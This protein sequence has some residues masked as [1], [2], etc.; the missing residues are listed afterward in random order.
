MPPDDPGGLPEDEYLGLISYVLEANGYPAGTSALQI[1]DLESIQI[2]GKEGLSEARNF[3]LV[4]VVGC[5][6]P[7]PDESW[8]LTRTSDPVLTGDRPST[9]AELS[10]ADAQPLGENTF[11]LV[12]VSP[13]APESYRGHRVEAKGLV[14]RAPNKDRINV[15]SL[16]ALGS[17]C[18]N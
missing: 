8:I 16:Q 14:Y 6:T 4:Q 5:L 11:R 12:S 10:R 3:S 2:L 9:P 18:V 7:G 17:T 1:A 15:S 13:F